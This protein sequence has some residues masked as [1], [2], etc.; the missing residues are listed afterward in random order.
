MCIKWE[1]KDGRHITISGKERCSLAKLIQ[2]I[3]PEKGID[4][5]DIEP[6]LLRVYDNPD[7]ATSLFKRAVEREILHS[8]DEVYHIPIPSM[9]SWLIS[10]Y[11]HERMEFPYALQPN[12]ALRDRDSGRDSMEL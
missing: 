7:K 1:R 12:P 10:N 9:R 11:A 2:N 8:Q 4:R 3:A 5:E 6:N